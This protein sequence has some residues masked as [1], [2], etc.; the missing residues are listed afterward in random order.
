MSS[1]SSSAFE[2]PMVNATMGVAMASRSMSVVEIFRVACSEAVA[3]TTAGRMLS[4]L[5]CSGAQ[6]PGGLLPAWP[7]LTM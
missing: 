4:G 2:H 5:R 1:N 3:G 6:D 7:A